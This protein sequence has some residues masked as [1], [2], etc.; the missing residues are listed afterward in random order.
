MRKLKLEE[1]NRVDVDTFKQQDK[2][3]VSVILDNIRSAHNVGS[4]F[5]T[6]DGFAIEHIYLCGITARPPHKEI[7][8]TAIGATMS[9]DWSYNE[10]ITKVISDLKLRGYKILGME[11]TNNT[12]S[13]QDLNIDPAQKYVIILGNEVEGVSDEAIALLDQA[14]EIPQFGTKHSFNVSVCAGIC[15]YSL[16]NGMR[17][18]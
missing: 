11:Q 1:L 13:L 10:N 12:V 3:A 8:K 16:S 18:M 6:C 14:V 15:L 5:R 4:I 7:N 9:V 2:I 17:A